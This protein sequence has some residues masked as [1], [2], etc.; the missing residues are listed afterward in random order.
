MSLD[1][2]C[3]QIMTAIK[4]PKEYHIAAVFKDDDSDEIIGWAVLDKDNNMLTDMIS[5]EDL[6]NWESYIMDD[7]DAD[8]DTPYVI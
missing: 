6:P 8:Y 4:L 1:E 3:R 7:C 5:T 2:L